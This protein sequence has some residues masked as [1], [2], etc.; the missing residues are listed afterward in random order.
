M[1][2]IIFSNDFADG[3]TD[4]QEFHIVP[5][6]VAATE[7]YMEGFQAGRREHER[8]CAE[9]WGER[10]IKAIERA[11]DPSYVDADAAASNAAVHARNAAHCY[12]NFRGRI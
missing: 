11:T 4:G 1:N 3:Y 7:P 6:G 8:Q 5:D 2:G 12:N 9:V 10:S